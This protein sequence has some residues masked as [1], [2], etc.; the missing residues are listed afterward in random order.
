MSAPKHHPAVMAAARATGARGPHAERI[1]DIIE[2]ETNHTQLRREYERLRGAAK[3][4]VRS[5]CLEDG[6]AW[7]DVTAAIDDLRQALG[8]EEVK[9]SAPNF[10]SGEPSEGDFNA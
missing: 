5:Y 10:N 6:A 8:R 1:A 3:K 2:R 7:R 4:A 9:K